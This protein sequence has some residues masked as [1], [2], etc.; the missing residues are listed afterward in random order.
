MGSLNSIQKPAFLM[1]NLTSFDLTSDDIGFLLT[2]VHQ[3]LL[4]DGEVEESKSAMLSNNYEE[5]EKVLM[6]KIQKIQHS[7]VFKVLKRVIK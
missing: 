6:S 3:F 2:D 1:N 5:I 7:T 4:F